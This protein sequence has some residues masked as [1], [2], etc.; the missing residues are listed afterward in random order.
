LIRREKLRYFLLNNKRSAMNGIAH[1]SPLLL[2]YGGCFNPPHSGHL[3]L[4]LECAEA[5]RPAS[6]LFIPCSVPPHK[7]R[8]N[9]LP[10]DL[11]VALLRAALDDLTPGAACSF[12]VSEVE[13]ERPGP[14]YT[15]DTLEILAG[16]HPGLRPVFIMGSDDYR[17]LADWRRGCLIPD[18]ADLVVVPRGRDGPD[19]FREWTLTF[20]PDAEY[21]AL[22]AERDV[23]AAFV[24][25]GGNGIRLLASPCLEISSSLVRERF[26]A[27]R[28]LSFLVPPGALRLMLEKR[29]DISGIWA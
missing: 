23:E 15:A 5:L 10:F 20:R 14:S 21:V 2:L 22:P 3:R 19:T 26:L 12:D 16:R 6:C 17:Q 7:E 24:L 25:P 11:R 27:G 9:L 8:H 18:M 13:G 29:R 28:D 4:A 1:V